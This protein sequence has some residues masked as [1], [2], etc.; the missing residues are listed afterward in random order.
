MVWLVVLFG[1]LA[2]RLFQMLTN[3]NAKPSFQLNTY[4]APYAPSRSISLEPTS[5]L[6]P[7]PPVSQRYGLRGSLLTPA[8]K[9]FLS[10]LA[11]VVGSEYHIESQVQ[12]SRI[13]TPKDSTNSFV[14]YRD[15]NRIKAKS[16]DF[17]LYDRDY[18]PYL[19]IELDDSTHLRWDRI[20]RDVF[21]DDIMK[22]VE[23]P[24]I[25]V[26]WAPSYDLDELRKEIFE[27]SKY[28]EA[29]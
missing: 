11:Q 1:K 3:R 20:Q 24:I 29:V 28:A 19:C 25:H 2:F 13:V 15:F 14:N 21:V 12:L 7:E 10:A 16:I 6:L 18:K 22:S 9:Q 23:L 5:I 27:F 8:E 26:K 4:V 17:V